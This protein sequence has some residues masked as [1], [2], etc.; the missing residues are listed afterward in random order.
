MV[1]FFSL[2]RIL[3]IYSYEDITITGETAA[4]F[5]FRLK[6]MSTAS[7][8]MSSELERTLACLVYNGRLQVSVT[9]SIVPVHAL[10]TWVCHGP[11]SN[12]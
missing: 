4:S 3:Y 10:N 12:T 6:Y 8:Y 5:C 1:F 11:V 2:L 9:Q 7:V